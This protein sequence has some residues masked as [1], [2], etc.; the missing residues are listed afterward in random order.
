MYRVGA[1]DNVSP[2]GGTTMGWVGGALGLTALVAII[3]K[4]V[5]VV[6][7][8][9]ARGVGGQAM[10][11]AVET[12]SGAFAYTLAALL[13]ALVCV[14]SFELARARHIHVIVRSIV[15]AVSGLVVALASPAVMERLPTG[16]SLALAVVTSL[17]SLL[18]GVTVLRSP[19][20]RALGGI[21]ALLSICALLRVL[22]WETSAMS[23][24]RGSLSL[25]AVARGFS[26]AA[27]SFQAL[28]A[29]FAAAWIGTRSRW[30]G[31]ILANL[32][33][34]LAFAITWVAARSTE[35]PSTIEAIL[36]TSLPA[37]AGI[38]PAPYLLGT[39]AAY[40]VPASILLAAVALL[41]RAQSPAVLA[42]LALVL[43]SNGSFDVPLHA[44]LVS[45]G[46]Q[47]A[48]LAM[49]KRAS[50]DGSGRRHQRPVEA[51]PPESG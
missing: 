3:A 30:R 31:R 16:A 24:E 33:I 41:E 5:G 15:V 40:L 49:A 28:A 7:T 27:I 29:L 2:G 22:T 35:T 21:L 4:T 50:G 39:I 9:G 44:L 18:A 26:T 25:H 6:V 43:L 12:I 14:A 8:P 17:T 19:G 37:A 1:L 36:R 48:L 38:I 11:T 51:V 42:P 10:V 45:A 32:A 34:L 47:W 46:A 13:I 23:F 20:T